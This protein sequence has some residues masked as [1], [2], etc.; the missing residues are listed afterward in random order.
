M[1]DGLNKAILIGQLGADPELKNLDSGNSVLNMRLATNE[2]YLKD[3]QR[4]QRT[5]W[6]NVTVWGKRAVGLGGFLS[7]GMTI[8][9]EGRIQTRSFEDRQGNKQYRTDVVATN[10]VVVGGKGDRR[11][12]GGTSAAPKNTQPAQSQSSF[13]D[14]D[15]IPF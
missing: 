13:A 8:C 3:G 10:V 11:S 9:V 6:H 12:S 1:A 14:D 2:T 5:D 7:K 15:D 4:Q